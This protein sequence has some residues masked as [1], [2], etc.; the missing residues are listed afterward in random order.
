MKRETVLWRKEALAFFVGEPDLGKH[1]Q[2]NRF[3]SAVKSA[4]R[5]GQKEYQICTYS[6]KKDTR[7]YFDTNKKASNSILIVESPS[8]DMLTKTNLLCAEDDILILIYNKGFDAQESKVH[9]KDVLTSNKKF[10]LIKQGS[11]KGITSA[12]IENNADKIEATPFALQLLTIPLMKT[13]ATI[14]RLICASFPNL[15]ESQYTVYVKN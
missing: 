13:L 9:H 6:Q 3:K 4:K 14:D 1:I 7:C 2:G 8:S 15:G 12:V 11:F 10:D 5:I